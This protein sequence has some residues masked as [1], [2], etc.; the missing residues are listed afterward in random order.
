MPNFLLIYA[1]L[2][3]VV[4][5]LGRK[6][7]LGALRT[8]LLSLL[9]TPFVTFVYLLLFASIDSEDGARRTRIGDR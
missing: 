7:R 2:C 6:T 9:L 3:A 1:V 8:L 4:A 5:I